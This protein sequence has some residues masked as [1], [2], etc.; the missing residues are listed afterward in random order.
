MTP[1]GQLQRDSVMSLISK[2]VP[3]C[4]GLLSVATFVRLFGYEQSVAMR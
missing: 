4:M 3:G 2:L 1:E